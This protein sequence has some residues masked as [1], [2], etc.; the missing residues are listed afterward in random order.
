[1]VRSILPSAFLRTLCLP[2]LLALGAALGCVDHSPTGTT[3]YV[4]DNNTSSIQIWAD[5]EKVYT[6]AQA[7]TAVD[8][9]DRTIQSTVLTNG[10]FDLAWGGLAVDSTREMLYAVSEK[11]VV[12]V[13]TKANTQNGSISNN[14]DIFSYNLGSSSDGFP[15]STFGQASIDTG[16]NI[17]YVVQTATDGSSTRVWKVANPS[18]LALSFASPLPATSYAMTVGSD[19]FGSGVAVGTSGTIYGLF[20]GGSTIYTS[21]GAPND[22]PRLRQGP[23]GTFPSSVPYGTNLLM[24]TKPKLANPLTFGALGYDTQNNLLFVASGPNTGSLP[25]VVAF[26]QSQFTHNPF[27][28][29]PA[30]SLPD[31]A[32]SLSLGSTAL[33]TI[34]HPPNAD[35]LLGATY[36]PPATTGTGTGTSTLLIWKSPGGGGAAVKAALPITNLEIRGMAIG[37]TN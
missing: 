35:Y 18:Q 27:D 31:T 9:P 16:N 12:Y 5:V 22:G 33:R 13:I 10:N 28:Q 2:A 24:G 30:L 29:D 19:T 1:M 17:L 20:G 26:T 21:L 4:F 7:G 25:L 34:S 15:T 3:L 37:G 6:A 32:A 11:G 23:G 14:S 36:T 8:A